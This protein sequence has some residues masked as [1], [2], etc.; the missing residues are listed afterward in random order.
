M[1]ASTPTRCP[2]QVPD[3]SKL[4]RAFDL[5]VATLG[6]LALSP[7]LA[8]VAVLIKVTLKG[9]VFHRSWRSGLLG[10]P[11]RMFKFRTMVLGAETLGG[12]STGKNDPRVTGIGR[13]L[14]R[15]KIDELPQLL[16]VL[17]GEMSIVGPRPEFPFYTN[18][19][20][21]E[22]RLIL[23]VRPGITDYAS[24]HFRNLDEWLGT[25]QP[26]R[27]Y[28][29]KVRPVKNALRVRYAKEHNFKRDLALIFQTLKQIVGG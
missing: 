24:I 18:Q 12:L 21:E 19:Y 9:P 20:S 3:I 6:L 26:D 13:I 23:T 27:V 1:Q 29:E 4:K 25:E 7:L 28:E 8:V 22:E 10:R 2:E 15:Y 16:N 11:F 14:R 5:A 17:R